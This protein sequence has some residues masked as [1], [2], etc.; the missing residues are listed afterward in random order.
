[1]VTGVLYPDMGVGQPGTLDHRWPSELSSLCW[2]VLYQK[3]DGGTYRKESA[4]VPSLKDCARVGWECSP[5]KL[6]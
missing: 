4:R 5:L 6:P 2:S 3:R 1:M